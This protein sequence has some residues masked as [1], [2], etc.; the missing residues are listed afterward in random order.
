[1]KKIF[2]IGDWVISKQRNHFIL[3]QV[4]DF[5]NHN[6]E[7]HLKSGRVTGIMIPEKE[8]TFLEPELVKKLPLD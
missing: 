7:I 6:G 4:D 8:C 2:E 1:M 5:E 3:F